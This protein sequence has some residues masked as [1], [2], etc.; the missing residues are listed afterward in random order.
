LEAGNAAQLVAGACRHRPFDFDKLM[1]FIL[2]RCIAALAAGG[3]VV[4]LTPDEAT[5]VE[6][7]SNIVISLAH[8][9]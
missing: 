5:K 6:F 2:H 8:I 4:K 9:L 7:D 1:K 3:V